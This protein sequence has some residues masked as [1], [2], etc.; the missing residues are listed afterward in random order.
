VVKRALEINDKKKVYLQLVNIY[1]NSKKYEPIEDILKLLVKKFNFD[2]DVWRK[3][4]EVIFEMT[5][6]KE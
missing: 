5:T 3:Y 2:T 1:K 4:F 6:L